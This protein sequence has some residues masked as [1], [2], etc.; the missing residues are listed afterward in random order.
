MTRHIVL[1]ALITLL[2]SGCAAPVFVAGTAAG[3]SVASD[4][5]SA[6]A[7][8]ED[9]AIEFKATK[10]INDDLQLPQNI[11][12]SVTSFNG[13]VL[14]TGQVPDHATR[15]YLSDLIGKIG[16]IRRLHNELALDQPTSMMT[17]SH[18][19]W[20]TT[21]VKSALLGAEDINGIQIKVVTENGVVYL[22]GVVTP[23]EGQSAAAAAQKVSGVKGIVKVFEYPE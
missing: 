2:S 5:R 17:R 6:G 18:D 21:K 15:D 12:V 4:R 1:L 14:L 23:A 19:A 8:V 10:A 16:K 20:L 9:Q 13:F 3:A 11:H 7:V 22:M